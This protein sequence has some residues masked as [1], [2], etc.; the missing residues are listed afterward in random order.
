MGDEPESLTLEEPRADFRNRAGRSARRL[1]ETP[2]PVGP[3]HLG[4]MNAIKRLFNLASPLE[5][6]APTTLRVTI[7]QHYGNRL[8][9]GRFRI[10][11]SGEDPSRLTPDSESESVA[12]LEPPCRR[13]AS[14]SI[15]SMPACRAAGDA[16]ATHRTTTR[17]SDS[18]SR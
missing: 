7:A 8:V 17:D 4:P 15:N 9:L 6:T 13:R 10:T 3:F 5:V 1:T 2:R 11:T 18:R 16:G 12:Q 14:S